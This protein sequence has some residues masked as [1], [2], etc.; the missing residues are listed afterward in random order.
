MKQQDIST[1]YQQKARYSPG[2]RK[3]LEKEKGIHILFVSIQLQEYLTLGTYCF[4]SVLVRRGSVIWGNQLI[5]KS[6]KVYFLPKFPAQ[7][8]SAECSPAPRRL[9]EVLPSCACT[10]QTV[11]PPSVLSPKRNMSLLSIVHWPELVTCPQLNGKGDQE[12]KHNIW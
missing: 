2:H 7:H 3:P 8:W 4:T 12:R 5:L 6:C 9:R 10:I 11:W 1:G